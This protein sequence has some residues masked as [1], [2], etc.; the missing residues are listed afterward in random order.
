MVSVG[1]I[2]RFSGKDQKKERE[3]TSEDTSQ[4]GIEES[5]KG[6]GRRKKEI[7]EESRDLDTG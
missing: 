2:S 7:Q 5:G 4:G 6:I 1:A 3:I